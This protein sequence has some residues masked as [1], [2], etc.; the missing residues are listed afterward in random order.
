M[1][2]WVNEILIHWWTY[3]SE[4]QRISQAGDIH[5]WVSILKALKVIRL[6]GISMGLSAEKKRG[7]KTE[8]LVF[9]HYKYII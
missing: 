2:F 9:P 7:P 6:N 1:N 5:F 3:E 8:P 4:I